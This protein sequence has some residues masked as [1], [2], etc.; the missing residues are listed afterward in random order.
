MGI[1]ERFD[2]HVDLMFDLQWLAF[3]ADITRV[4][5]FMLGRELNF[6]TYPEIGITEG[7]HGLSHHGDRPDQL[8]RYAKVNIY[9]AERF[10]RF[11]EKLRDTEDGDG[12]LLDH[13]MFLY[14]AGLSNPNL[15]AHIDLPLAVFGGGVK[16]RHLACPEHTPVM[17]LLLTMLDKTGV[18][19]DSLGDSTGR[20]NIEP[21]SDL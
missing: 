5:T 4:T 14:G 13:S 2:E 11:L 7:H 20:L 8:A 10:A 16:G 6:R 21:I 12:T 15:H 17:N 9:Q 19:I 18:P 1:P 3:Q